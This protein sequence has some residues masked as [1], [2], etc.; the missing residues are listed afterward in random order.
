MNFKEEFKK[1]IDE[2][3]IVLFLKGT[4]DMPVCGFSKTVVNLLNH[5]GVDFKDVNILEDPEMKIALSELSG[6]PTFPQL[7]VQ[8]KLL[9]GCDIAVEMHQ[10]GQLLDALDVNS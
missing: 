3:T 1:I 7:F 4:K 8:G 2:N 6:W 5:Y 10:N 9:G